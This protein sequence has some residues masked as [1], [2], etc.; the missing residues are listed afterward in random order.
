VLLRG[1]EVVSDEL[2]LVCA[3]RRDEQG[4]SVFLLPAKA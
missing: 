3:E 4:Q 2:L 1:E